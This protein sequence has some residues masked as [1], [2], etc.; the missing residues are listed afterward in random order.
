MKK[1]P[2]LPR[3]S[4]SNFHQ[5]IFDYALEDA[6]VKANVKSVRNFRQDEQSDPQVDICSVPLSGHG[7]THLM[8]VR[9]APRPTAWGCK[10]VTHGLCPMTQ[11]A[12]VSSVSCT[13]TNF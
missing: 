11:K 10:K 5:D 9:G 7:D 12:F 13:H 2:E 1:K 3:R 8:I 4:V 6:F